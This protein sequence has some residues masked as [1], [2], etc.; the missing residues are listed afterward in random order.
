MPGGAAYHR[1]VVSVEEVC[2]LARTLPRSTE[3]VVR[4]RIKFRVGSIVWLAFSH[5]ETELGFAFPKEWR[6]ALVDSEPGKFM[7]PRPSDLRFNWAE[8]RLA[9]LGQDEMRDF[10]L[11]AWSM[12]VPKYVVEE[13]RRSAQHAQDDAPASA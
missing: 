10:V 3:V 12:V 9:A 2:K 5:D 11:E 1:V 7:L 13:Y 6:Q 8:A 4:G